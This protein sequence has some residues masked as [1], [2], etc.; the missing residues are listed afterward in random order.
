VRTFRLGL[1]AGYACEHSGV[2]CTS[3]WAI[4]VE[5]HRQP[6]MAARAGALT[7]PRI[8]WLT[9]APAGAP[10]EVAGVLAQRPDGACVFHGAAGGCL[11]YE[12]RPVSC[13]H[14]PFVVV[15]DPRGVHISLSQYC[16]TAAALLF[17]HEASLDIVAGDP[18]L[19]EGR[20]PEGLD[21]REALPPV[22]SGS[23]APRLMAW[24]EVSVWEQDAVR[25]WGASTQTPP[26]SPDAAALMDIYATV[27]PA[28]PPW[29]VPADLE[30]SWHRWGADG[31]HRWHAVIGRYLAARVVASWALHLGEGVALVDASVAQARQVLQAEM[32]RVCS[33]DRAPLTRARMTQAL[34]RA[35]LLLLH[36][37]DPRALAGVAANTL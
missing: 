37:G 5:R 12:A 1:H 30:D 25:R 26:P 27:P 16:P 35:D 3:G 4:P 8:T 6:A 9:P 33:A 22:A 20:L 14:F 18:V 19:P 29:Y 31:W 2:C 7:D 10:D 28:L 24:S 32:V 15:L 17:H 13:E 36:H 21:A 34:R 23:G 11:V